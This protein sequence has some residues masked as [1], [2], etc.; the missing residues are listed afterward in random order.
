MSRV[1]YGC[2][3]RPAIEYETG[4]HVGQ[5]SLTG[6][7]GAK[8]REGIVV[9]DFSGHKGDSRREGKLNVW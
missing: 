5:L 9:W 3:C 2:T 8:E 6:Q 1:C 7:Y 4:G